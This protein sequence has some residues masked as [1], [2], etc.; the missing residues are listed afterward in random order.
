MV[1]R[2]IILNGKNVMNKVVDVRMFTV[3]FHVEKFWGKKT[4][5]ASGKSNLTAEGKKQWNK[6]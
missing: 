5:E 4:S 6:Q 1:G 2:E 3:S